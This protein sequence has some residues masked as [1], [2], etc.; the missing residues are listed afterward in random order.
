MLLFAHLKKIKIKTKKWPTNNSKACYVI[1]ECNEHN[2]VPAFQAT[3]VSVLHIKVG[4]RCLLPNLRLSWCVSLFTFHRLTSSAYF[5]SF[6]K[7]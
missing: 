3:V 4:E 2:A 7:S 1:S 5:P 6:P